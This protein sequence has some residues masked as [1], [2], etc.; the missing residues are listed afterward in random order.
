MVA[1]CLASILLSQTKAPPNPTYSIVGHWKLVSK[2]H[3]ADITYNRDK[4]FQ[5][6]TRDPIGN[7]RKSNILM[8]GSYMMDGNTLYIEYHKAVSKVGDQVIEA[9]MPK[10]YPRGPA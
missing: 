10:T 1:L 3:V 4:T 2:K 7:G 6:H 5:M 9:T 8:S